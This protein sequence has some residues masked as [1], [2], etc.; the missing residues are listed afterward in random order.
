MNNKLSKSFIKHYNVC[1]LTLKGHKY[2]SKL[3]E[4]TYIFE[5]FYINL[6]IIIIKL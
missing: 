1:F 2:I 6:D 3:L 5:I 4:I